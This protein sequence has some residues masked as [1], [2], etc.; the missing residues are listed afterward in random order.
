MQ[1]LIER[2][3]LA[4]VE[5]AILQFPVRQC[6]EKLRG[7]REP[8]NLVLETVAARLHTQ[9][10]ATDSAEM[11]YGIDPIRQWMAAECH[12]IPNIVAGRFGVWHPD[13]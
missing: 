10:W 11:P 2:G 4:V 12:P 6:F 7:G 13:N 8:M 3:A 5:G 9:H 1:S